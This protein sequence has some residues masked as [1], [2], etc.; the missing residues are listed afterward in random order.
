MVCGMVSLAAAAWMAWMVVGL[1]LD[2]RRKP[3]PGL[4]DKYECVDFARQNLYEKYDRVW[5]DDSP[6]GRSA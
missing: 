5:E 1:W 6:T 3:N 4:Y 2:G